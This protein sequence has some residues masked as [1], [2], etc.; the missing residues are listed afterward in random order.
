MLSEWTYLILKLGELMTMVWALYIGDMEGR[1]YLVLF[2]S[3]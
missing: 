3:L 1:I 2:R